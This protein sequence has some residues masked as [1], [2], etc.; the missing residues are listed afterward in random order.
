[1][2]AIARDLHRFY[3][4]TSREEDMRSCEVPLLL[5]SNQYNECG[6]DV[7][8]KLPDMGWHICHRHR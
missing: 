4:I 3:S 8:C 2:P 6:D 1:M 5:V 7:A